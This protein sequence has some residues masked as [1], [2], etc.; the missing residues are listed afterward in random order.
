MTETLAQT[1][2]STAAPN[3]CAPRPAAAAPAH[4]MMPLTRGPC[5][6]LALAARQ[7]HQVELAHANLPGLLLPRLELGL[8]GR[9]PLCGRHKHA[10]GTC[11]SGRAQGSRVRAASEAHAAGLGEAAG[12]LP[13]SCCRVSMVMVRMLWERELSWFIRVAPTERFF[14]PTCRHRGSSRATHLLCADRQA[15]LEWHHPA[16]TTAPPALADAVAAC[17]AHPLPATGA[18]NADAATPA[19]LTSSTLFISAT[20]FTTNCMRS[21]TYTPLSVDSLSSSLLCAGFLDSRSRQ[22]GGPLVF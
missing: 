20:L 9:G 11:Q 21:L 16:S 8:R 12:C 13:G 6:A 19:S 18:P 22:G 7:I 4:L 10:F 17:M 2:C 14:L 3:L 1:C 15:L 5:L